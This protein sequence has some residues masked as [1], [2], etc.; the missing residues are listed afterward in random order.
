MVVGWKKIEDKWYYFNQNGEGTEGQMRTG[1]LYK[2]GKKHV[3]NSGGSLYITELPVNRTRQSKDNWCWAACSEMVGGYEVNNYRTQS[4]IVEYIKGSSSIDEGGTN[5]EIRRSVDYASRNSK[6][7]YIQNSP[8]SYEK[9][10][11]KID[12]NKPF[13][14]T[15]LWSSTNGHAIVCSG[16]NLNARSL[17]CI[18]PIYPNENSYYS[19]SRLVN[20]MTIS[21][22]TGNYD[23]TIYY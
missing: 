10:I 17:Q 21:S 16:Y 13:I 9:V 1:T 19:Y 15:I 8:F 12:A 3:F 18:D 11:D 14:L 7:S 6:V 5:D 4:D 2:N 22:G 23:C 20:G